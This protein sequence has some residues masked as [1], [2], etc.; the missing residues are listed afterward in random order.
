MSKTVNTVEL[1]TTTSIRKNPDNPRSITGQDMERLMQSI[2]TF[3]DMMDARPVIIDE[4]Y[5]VLGGNM[6]YEACKRLG[7][8]SIPCIRMHR[9]D[10]ERKKEFIVKDNVQ[11][12]QWEW[13]TLA[14]QWDAVDL[15]SWGLDVWQ[16]EPHDP[17]PTYRVTIEFENS[18]SLRIFEE[19]L[20]KQY[21]D[22]KMKVTDG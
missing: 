11:S 3:P 21:H 18:E 9:W 19:S 4:N 22:L 7:W 20:R 8:Q 12:G 10:Y 16:A 2:K 5:M 14:N 6:R 15:E 13:D 1:V 17:A